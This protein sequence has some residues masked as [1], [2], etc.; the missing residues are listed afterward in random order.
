MSKTICFEQRIGSIHAR[1][2]RLVTQ[3]PDFERRAE[4]IKRRRRPDLRLLEQW[5]LGPLI[6]DEQRLI[7]MLWLSSDPREEAGEIL[8]NYEPENDPTTTNDLYSMHRLARFYHHQQ[9]EELRRDKDL[10]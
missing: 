3:Q 4:R 7:A 9:Q 5:L 8:A 1:V 6:F 10:A 2:H